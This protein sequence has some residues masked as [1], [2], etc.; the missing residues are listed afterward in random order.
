MSNIKKMIGCM[1]DLW[2]A[3]SGEVYGTRGDIYAT[4][5]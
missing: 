3:R 4:N 2:K 5:A 1:L